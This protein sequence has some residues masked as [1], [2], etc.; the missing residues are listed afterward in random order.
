MALSRLSARR[1]EFTA[2][3]TRDSG[4]RFARSAAYCDRQNGENGKKFSSLRVAA[5]ALRRVGMAGPESGPGLGLVSMRRG[6]ACRI[7]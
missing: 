3:G 2:Q 4:H 1:A 5:A 6:R 7:P